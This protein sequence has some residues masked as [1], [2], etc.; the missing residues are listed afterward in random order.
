MNGIGEFLDKFPPLSGAEVPPA[1]D[2]G[3]LFNLKEVL[4]ND[5]QS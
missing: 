1:L 3:S 5:N 2:L 4:N